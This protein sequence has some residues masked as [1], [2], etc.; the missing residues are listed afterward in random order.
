MGPLAA[1]TTPCVPFNFFGG[2]GSISQAQVDFVT[3]TQHDYRE[4]ELFNASFNVS[5]EL[6]DLPAGPFGFAAGFEHRDQS[7]SFN[8]DPIVA[9]GDSAD[10]PAQ[11]TSGSFDV[12]ELYGEIRVPLLADMTFFHLLEGSFA[13]RY[14]T[15]STDVSTTTIKYGGRWQPFDDLTIRGGFTEGFRSASIG[16]L[17]GSASRFDQM[18]DDPCPYLLGLSGGTP[19]TATVLANC[20]TLG[21]PGAGSYV[22]F[23][24]QISVVTGGNTERC[25][26][27]LVG[28]AA[29]D[30]CSDPTAPAPSN[31]LGS[32][33]YLD[34]AASYTL[35]WFAD[36]MEF[37][38]G[39]NNI[40]KTDPPNCFSC[41]LNGF[42]PNTY[43]VPGR[44]GYVRLTFRP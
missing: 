40:T 9:M 35:P 36:R 18:L 7:G 6:F 29:A 13:V 15:Y 22:Q 23:N 5:A 14:S 25:P 41:Q 31:T 8:P 34:L 27:A 11:P 21:V 16:E 12:E 33:F 24:A 42:D 3:F 37:T 10:I 44:Y 26:A 30:G 4:Q 1:C 38:I 28:L 20:Q 2:P 17:F 39:A 43:D 32:R 19:A